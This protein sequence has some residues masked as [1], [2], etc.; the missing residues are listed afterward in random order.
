M[1]LVCQKVFVVRLCCSKL[2]RQILNLLLFLS[3]RLLLRHFVLRL[4]LR[5]FNFVVNI[6]LLDLCVLSLRLSE[7]ALQVFEKRA[8]KNFDVSNFD[9]LKPHA[10]ALCNR[11][12]ALTYLL[13]EHLTVCDKIVNC[14][15]GNFVSY[16]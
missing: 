4:Q 11:R 14:R 10:P 13:S 7:L 5:H 6:G 9:R 15:V 12:Q 3:V 8:R 1:L 16:D 2:S